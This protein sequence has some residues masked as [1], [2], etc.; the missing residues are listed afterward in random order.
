MSNLTNVLGKDFDLSLINAGGELIF[1]VIVF[2]IFY[3]VLNKV[4]DR[5]NNNKYLDLK[6]Y[7]PV[8][9]IQTLK[10]VFYLLIISGCFIFILASF[11]IVAED[12]FFLSLFDFA[13]STICFLSMKNE[14]L[15]DKILLF[16]LIP[17]GS[18]S[19][20]VLD[21]YNLLV[22]LDF[23]H[24]I[25]FVFVMKHFYHKFM[26]Y[27]ENNGLGIA[28]LLLFG[29]VFISM[30]A[31]HF[32]ENKSLLD[33]LVM[34]SNAFTSNGYAVLG[35]SIP[36]KVNSIFLVWSGYVISSVSTATLTAAIL[37]KH[38]NSKFDKLE[39]MIEKNNK[40]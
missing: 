16:F 13:L 38:F 20:L 22:L 12:N 7:M 24:L 39:E 37:L 17:Y 31:T 15:T 1:I 33:S 28:I 36:G 34:S 21:S 8:E 14:T 35:D 19:F 9:E 29:I 3:Y 18:I 25:A 26:D 10:Q 30:L 11:T 32:T 5:L 4:S 6:S 2:I 40:D 27:T 23:I